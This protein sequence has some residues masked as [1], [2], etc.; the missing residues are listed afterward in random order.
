MSEAQIQTLWTTAKAQLATITADAATLQAD[1]QTMENLR[2]QLATAG[3]GDVAE[4]LRVQIQNL[5]LG[6]QPYAQG[7]GGV[8]AQPSARVTLFGSE[9]T[10][11]RDLSQLGD[12]RPITVIHPG[13]L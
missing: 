8:P 1:L 4:W 10:L 3:G 12:R 5:G 9:P 11:L 7:P 2:S 6:Y 13:L